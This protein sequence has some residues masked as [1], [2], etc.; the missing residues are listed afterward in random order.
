ME[1]P[2]AIERAERRRDGLSEAIH[3]E[4]VRVHAGEFTVGRGYRT[5]R[6]HG[7]S[8]WLLM[9]TT[10][11]S[12]LVRTAVT[13]FVARPGEAVL[14]RPGVLHDYGTADETWSLAFAH[15]HPRAE[16]GALLDW[17]GLADGAGRMNPPNDVAE[18]ALTALRSSVRSSTGSLG[19]AELFAVN[20]L[21]TA[22][23]WLSTS[24]SG[25]GALDDRVLRALE[26]IG[27]NLAVDLSVETLARVAHVSPS[28]LNR[29]F[30]HALGMSPQRVVERERLARA[31]VMLE[32]TNRPIGAIA[33]D[34]GWKDQLY[35]SRRFRHLY[36]ESPTEF[37]ARRRP[38]PAV[39]PSL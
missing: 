39:D 21:E 15:F 32:S 26:Y 35:F 36:R 19:Q 37:R 1:D 16:W 9:F 3:P 14:L 20:A 31:A 34:V 23:L 30:S 28:R 5:W 8:D 17:P 13:S 2:F 25:P 12:G 38:V 10:G 4:V 7:T 29:L 18:R 33:R 11:G 24:G 6:A 27:E 22:L